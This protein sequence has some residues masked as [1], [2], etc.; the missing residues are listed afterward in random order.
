M[1][2][3]GVE[4]SLRGISK[5][6]QKVWI[7]AFPWVGRRE[8]AYA[9]GPR[10]S[11]GHSRLNEEGIKPISASSLRFNRVRA[12]SLRRLR[13]WFQDFGWKPKEKS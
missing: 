12:N 3:R 2:G 7:M 1:L 13:A 9:Y 6:R 11:P 5:K 8:R 10:P 4:G